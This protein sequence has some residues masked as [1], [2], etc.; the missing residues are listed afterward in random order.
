MSISESRL[1]MQHLYIKLAEKLIAEQHEKEEM[2]ES[3]IPLTPSTSFRF[4]VRK[5]RPMNVP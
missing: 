2:P 3:I 1:S 5:E 4:I